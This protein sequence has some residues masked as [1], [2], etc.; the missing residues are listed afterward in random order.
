[1]VRIELKNL[2]TVRIDRS[3]TVHDIHAIR[4]WILETINTESDSL[5]WSHHDYPNT[6]TF[7]MSESTW[8]F[9]SY[10]FNPGGR[11]VRKETVFMFTDPVAAVAFKLRWVEGNV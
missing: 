9:S 5:V 6:F 11:R 1:M 3:L 4:I 8:G 10:R 7:L 2:Y